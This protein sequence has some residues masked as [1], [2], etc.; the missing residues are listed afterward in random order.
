MELHRV[1]WLLWLAI[2]VG[3]V[4]CRRRVPVVK[5]SP[6][7][8]GPLQARA[9]TVARIGATPEA[10]PSDLS[11][12]VVTDEATLVATR[13]EVCFDLV[14]R[15]ARQVDSALGLYALEC[16]LDDEVDIEGVLRSEAP[17][18]TADYPYIGWSR[19]GV[20]SVAQPRRRGRSPC[21]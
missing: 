21:A 14:V 12:D 8:A 18:E 15:T 3:A 5:L 11:R 2:G 9:L 13:E 17:P 19:A 7:E 6:G 4:T 10:P 1:L 16:S 20:G